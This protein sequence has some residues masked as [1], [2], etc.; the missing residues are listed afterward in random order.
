MVARLICGVS[1]VYTSYSI[2]L[3]MLNLNLLNLLHAHSFTS[4]YIIC[5]YYLSLTALTCNGIEP[6]LQG[7]KVLDLTRVLAGPT[8]TM[9][10][11]DFG[12]NVIKVEEIKSRDD[13]STP[14]WFWCIYSQKHLNPYPRNLASSFCPTESLTRLTRRNMSLTTRD[15][16][17]SRCKPQQVLYNSQLK[18]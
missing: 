7:V 13:T 2:L 6:P 17:P 5:Q 18:R 1:D 9:L 10:L 15:R 3:V 11:A 12:A 14:V 4:P 16:L 8:C